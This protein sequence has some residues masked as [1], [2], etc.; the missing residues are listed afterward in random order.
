[1]E[2]ADKKYCKQK[3]FYM[4]AV[5]PSTMYWILRY[6]RWTVGDVQELWRCATEGHSYWAW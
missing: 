1:M 5:S 2:V 3:Y 4:S 6:S